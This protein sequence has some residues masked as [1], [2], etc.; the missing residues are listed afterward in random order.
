MKLSTATAFLSAS[1]TAMAIGNYTN[2][3]SYVYVSDIDT[4]VIT[5][6]N[7]GTLTCSETPVT[8]GLTV[9]TETKEFITTEYTTYCPLTA[10]TVVP[11]PTLTPT[12]V[13]SKASTQAP[14][15][16]TEVSTPAKPAPSSSSFTSVVSNSTSK[17][18]SSILVGEGSKSFIHVSSALA[19]VALFML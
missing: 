7:C 11:A 10:A 2:S 4:T 8:T 1:S 19:L 18:Y 9:I 5:I 15:V 12:P 3:T 16:T 13:P 14:P 6:T 17:S